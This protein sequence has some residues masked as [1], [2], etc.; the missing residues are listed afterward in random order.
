ML[1]YYY[2]RYPHLQWVWLLSQASLGPLCAWC[3]PGKIVERNLWCGRCVS[4]CIWTRGSSRVSRSRKPIRHPSA[5]RQIGPPLDPS[6]MSDREKLKHSLKLIYVFPVHTRADLSN[7]FAIEST[8]K[9]KHFSKHVPPKSIFWF[10]E[11]TLA[12]KLRAPID[13]GRKKVSN[14]G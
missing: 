5:G 7:I 13:R 12:A 6:L 1:L 2:L 9:S 8:S 11:L 3:S 14:I 10:S 4:G